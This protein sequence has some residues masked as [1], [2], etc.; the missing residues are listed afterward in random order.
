M[1]EIVEW[2]SCQAS[3][4]HG[5]DVRHL[6]IRVQAVL[7]PHRSPAAMTGCQLHRQ[8]VGNRDRELGVKGRPRGRNCLAREREPN[9]NGAV[10]FD[11]R[12]DEAPLGEACRPVGRST[13]ARAEPRVADRYA[14]PD[15]LSL[16]EDAAT[17]DEQQRRIIGLLEARHVCALKIDFR[18]AVSGP[19]DHARQSP[20]ALFNG[21]GPGDFVAAQRCQ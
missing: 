17:A 3:D 20:G 8:R 5:I 12:P 15:R 19:Y 11:A 6:K 13:I 16:R 7:E 21:D 9:D 1:C 18:G 4:G 14:A 10:G 2:R